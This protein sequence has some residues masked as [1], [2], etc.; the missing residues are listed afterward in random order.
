MD[1]FVARQPILSR[2]QRTYG[3][4]LLFRNGLTNSFPEIDGETAS[5]KVL[6]NSFFSIGMDQL[7][8]EKKAFINFTQGLL[9]KKIPMM[10]PK[11]K[12]VI[13][14]LEDIEPTEEVIAACREM[15]SS[16]YELA[17]DDFVYENKLK[18]L[19]DLA[20]IIKFDFRLTP[21]DQI[22]AALRSLSGNRRLRFLAEKVE[23]QEEFN[24]AVSMGFEYFQGYF[25]SRPQIIKG[26]EIP[27]STMNLLQIVAEANREDFDFANLEKHILN[28][29]AISY[30]LLRYINS[31]FFRR[32]TE[33]SSI[34][35]A[36]VLLG[37][38]EVKRFIS[39]M[40]IARLAPGK[41]DELVRTS[42][43]RA[44]MAELI[45]KYTKGKYNEAEVFTMGLFS[46]IDA[47][48]DQD[49]GDLMGKLPLAESIKKALVEGHGPLAEFMGL[50]ISYEKGVWD[51]F[52]KGLEKLNLE[53]D[54]VPR[55]YMEAV[56]WAEALASMQN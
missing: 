24:Q 7:V 2:A 27:S 54:I 16:G 23:T 44:K 38:R 42:I 19:I 30:K 39:L 35:Q 40:L 25:F 45:A 14:V 9:V 10:F 53:E 48:L 15:A 33:I 50:I 6:S 41:P 26:K 32:V 43:I 5:S 18:P 49:I 31:A 52:H 56:G 8:F 36:L 55:C 29:I 20:N 3:Y 51:E 12:I 1:I 17:L 4:E 46:L 47:I 13:E 34:K 11:E 21:I 28:D 37:E 22:K